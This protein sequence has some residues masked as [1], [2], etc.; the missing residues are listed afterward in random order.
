MIKLVLLKEA[1]SRLPRESM[2]DLGKVYAEAFDLMNM[3]P[4]QKYL[5]D[6]EQ[7]A[8][9]KEFMSNI[10]ISKDEYLANKLKFHLLR[11]RSKLIKNRNSANK[12]NFIDGAQQ[13]FEKKKQDLAS[14]K[15]SWDTDKAIQAKIN[16]IN[17]REDEVISVLNKWY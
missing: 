4:Q 14:I 9:I 7:I 8:K 2:F 6:K 5:H 17:L 10:E 13:Y 16:E 1:V 11:D 3:M 12:A 15:L